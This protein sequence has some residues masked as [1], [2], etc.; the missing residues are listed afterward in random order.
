M[1]YDSI[2]STVV[3]FQCLHMSSKSYIQWQ[4]IWGIC[5]LQHVTG[6][7]TSLPF[8]FSDLYGPW[9]AFLVPTWHRFYR[10]KAFCDY[11]MKTIRDNSGKLSLYSLIVK[12]MFTQ[13]LSTIWCTSLS[14]TM[15]VSHYSRRY[16]CLCSHQRT[17]TPFLYFTGR[18]CM[19]KLY[20][21]TNLTLHGIFNETVNHLYTQ[22]NNETSVFPGLGMN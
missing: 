8:P 19:Q 18:N 10:N 11:F 7:N 16:E 22:S 13:I 3:W 15:Q 14:V 6:L 5:L 12:F 1:S 2:A 20:Q 4:Y 21:S 17:P 9:W